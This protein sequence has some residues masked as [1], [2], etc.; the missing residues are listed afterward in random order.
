MYLSNV[1]P[2]MHPELVQRKQPNLVQHLMCRCGLHEWT[3]RI[4]MGAKVN[5][6]VNPEENNVHTV[7]ERFF[8]FSAPICKHCAKQLRPLR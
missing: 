6:F 5:D 2:D 1:I 4:Q 3:S 7:V 8:D